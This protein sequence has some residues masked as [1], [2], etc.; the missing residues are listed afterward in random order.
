MNLISKSTVSH[1]AIITAFGLMVSCGSGTSDG[2]TPPPLNDAPQFTSSA[3]ISVEENNSGTIYIAQASDAN[4][5]P[6]AF[7]I[8]GGDDQA[9]F[10]INESSGELSFIQPP[11]F[12]NPADQNTDNI[13]IVQLTVS[14]GRG[15]STQLTLSVT[16]T[17]EIQAFQIKRVGT[18]FN[19]PLFAFDLSDGTNRL[20]ILEKAGRARILDPVT[21]QIEVE[22]FFDLSGEITSNSERGLLSAVF[23]PDFT[24]DR[25]VYINVT[26]ADGHT[27]I[28]RYSLSAGQS[29]RM[30]TS[31]FDLIIRIEQPFTNHNGG[32]I[33]FD[34]NGLLIIPT[35]DGGSGGDP[36]DLAQDITSLLGKVLRLDI[37]GD[38]FPADD[39]RTYRIPSGNFDVSAQPGGRPEIYAIGLRNP[40]RAGIIPGQNAIIMADVGQGAI[41]EINILPLGETGSRNFGWSV[42]EGTRDFKGPPQSEFTPPV[43]E[44]EHGSGLREG[45]SV[46][47][48]YVYTGPVEALQGDYIF[49]DFISNNFWAVPLTALE[50]GQTLSSDQFTVLNDEF[51]PDAGNLSRVASFGEDELG[52]LFI[53][54]IN[55]DVF[56]LVAQ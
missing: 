14:D 1:G 49:C 55:G 12:E 29:D 13:Y 18:G 11:D 21:G 6:L 52:N 43:L 30:D 41:E 15:G 34:E 47:G 31:S 40:F 8:I 10:T 46:T 44:Y 3:A 33:G 23:S 9:L 37:S 26:N 24:Q 56:Q 19:Q 32:W 50:L 28:R 36:N 27:E 16:I 17:D 25:Q 22:D 20:V 48:G 39:M 38:D 7:S 4:G 53:I 5:D 51:I 35:G 54:S 45:N 42:V 2:V